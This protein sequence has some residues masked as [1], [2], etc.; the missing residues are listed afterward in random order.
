M[1]AKAAIERA[2]NEL[3]RFVEHEQARQDV[4]IHRTSFII[5]LNSSIKPDIKKLLNGLKRLIL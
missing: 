5:S 1:A 3:A 4:N 2:H